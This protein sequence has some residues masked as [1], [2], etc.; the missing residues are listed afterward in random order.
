MDRQTALPTRSPF[1]SPSG[2]ALTTAADRAVRALAR[3]RQASSGDDGELRAA[4]CAFVAV[5]RARGAAPQAAVIATKR[6]LEVAGIFPMWAAAHRALAE[7]AVRWCIE[8]Y[9]RPNGGA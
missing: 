5:L 4:V 1:H 7:R 9:Y 2:S 3:H 6:L 8:E